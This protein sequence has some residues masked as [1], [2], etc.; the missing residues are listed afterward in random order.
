MSPLKVFSCAG[1]LTEANSQT[2]FKK[3]ETT[4]TDILRA[5]F[6]LL[7][8]ITPAQRWTSP[9]YDCRSAGCD[10]ATNFGAQLLGDFENGVQNATML[11][12]RNV[13][14]QSAIHS[15]PHFEP[16]N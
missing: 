2:D 15:A 14:A 4:R 11:E 10:G 16:A 1:L 13:E 5:V 3:R 8:T 12:C 9:M 6:A 7:P